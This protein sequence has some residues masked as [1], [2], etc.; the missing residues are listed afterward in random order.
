[1]LYGPHTGYDNVTFWEDEGQPLYYNI[2]KKL[3]MFTYHWDDQVK[4][5]YLLGDVINTFVT[6][7]DPL[8]IGCKA[9]YVVDNN[10]MGVIIWEITGDYIETYP[11]SGVIS[12]TPLLDTVQQVFNQAKTFTLKVFLEGPYIGNHTMSTALAIDGIVPLSQPYNIAPWHYSGS[13]SITGIPN[14]NVVDWILVELREAASPELATASS[15]IA[16]KAGFILMD[17]SIV[18]SDGTSDLHFYIS[19]VS[20]VYA[21]VEHRNHLGIMSASPL[22]E[23]NGVY[24]Y[25]FTSGL[26]QVYGEMNGHK[27]IDGGVWGMVGADGNADGQINNLDKNDVWLAQQGA[28]GYKSGDFNMDSQVTD[29]DINSFWIPNTG[30]GAHIPH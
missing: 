17:G 21:V 8:S 4:C 14:I 9:Q 28:F 12:G 27:E 11:G 2:N 16:R 30:F 3:D 24:S 20:N 22:V 23:S 29:E 7:D 25:D 6:F 5:P 26:G 15:A 18:A 1:M 19:P 13:E 10:A